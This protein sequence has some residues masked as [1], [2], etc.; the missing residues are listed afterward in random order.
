MRELLV[1]VYAAE[2]HTR[3]RA[4]RVAGSVRVDKS[5]M[6]LLPFARS[7]AFETAQGS[8]FC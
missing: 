5:A 8:N 1:I 6:V 2:Q 4:C 7:F 3:E